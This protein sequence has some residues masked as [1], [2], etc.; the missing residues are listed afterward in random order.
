LVKE[1]TK[2][3]PK[4]RKIGRMKDKGIYDLKTYPYII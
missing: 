3:I 1:K 4:R 2:K